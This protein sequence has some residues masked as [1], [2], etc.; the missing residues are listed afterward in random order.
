MP[1]PRTFGRGGDLGFPPA[2]MMEGL[3][4]HPASGSFNYSE[5]LVDG[6]K[7]I[8]EIQTSCSPIEQ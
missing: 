7:T 4:L 2:T 5:T 3:L 8:G 1:H 6:R